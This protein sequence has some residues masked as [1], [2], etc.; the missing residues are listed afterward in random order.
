MRPIPD[1]IVNVT[2]GTSPLTVQFT[3][4]SQYTESVEW[5]FGDGNTSTD[6]SPVYTYSEAGLYGVS[7]I[8]IGNNT[9]VVKTVDDYI[10]VTIPPVP[11]FSANITVGSFPLTVQFTDNSSYTESVEWNFGDGNTST[12]KNP[13]HTYSEFGFYSVSL[14][15]TGNGTSV[16][17]TANGFINV[18]IP[19]LPDFSVNVTEGVFP[20]S[21]Q[22]TDES[23]YA[24]FVEWNFG[25]GNT[26]TY[27]N[28]VHT[29][30]KPSL[31]TVSL[32]ATGNGTST[33]KTVDDF[34]NVTNPPIPDFSANI[35]EGTSP[36]TVQFTD[37]SSY[38]ESFEWDF[39]D[40]NSSSERSP[41]HTYSVAGLYTVALTA[42]GNNTSVTKSLVITSM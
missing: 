32:T 21:V 8:A 7:L 37:N 2:E 28:P 40:G 9:S 19:P 29:Y 20:L 25:D 26:S 41:V 1:F 24:E 36:L 17:K 16:T 15:A 42:T 14:V 31:Y 12:E 38:A 35:T 30:S 22:F 39:G 11:D 5:D 23:Q 13:V 33:M 4:E 6:R 3:D 34:I 18:T 27:R 10:N